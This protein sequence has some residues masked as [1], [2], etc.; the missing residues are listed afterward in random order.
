MC[1]LNY[2]APHFKV[3]QQTLKYLILE[4]YQQPLSLDQL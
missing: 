3:S 4:Y 2:Q 1:N